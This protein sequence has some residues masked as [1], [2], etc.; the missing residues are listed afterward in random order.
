MLIAIDPGVYKT[1]IARFRDGKLIDADYVPNECISYE[2]CDRLVVESQQIYPGSPV[3]TSDL[4]DLAHAAGMV[5]GRFEVAPEWVLP[6]KW[7]GNTPKAI[8]TKRIEKCLTPEEVEALDPS[9][10]K[11]LRHN[12]LDAVGIGLWALG[13]F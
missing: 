3:R 4:I 2:D 10:P 9:V 8:C 13:R 11:S 5:A 7:K 6:K 12:M 1:G